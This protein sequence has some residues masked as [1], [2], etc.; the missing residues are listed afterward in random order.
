MMEVNIPLKY[1]NMFNDTRACSNSDS[2]DV[3]QAPPLAEHFRKYVRNREKSFNNTYI[4]SCN[5]N[6]LNIQSF[7]FVKRVVN[8]IVS[9]SHLIIYNK[10]SSK[11]IRLI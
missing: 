11:I 10:M 4:L 5:V 7:Q 6:K 3:I 2:D 1:D 8:V 9:G